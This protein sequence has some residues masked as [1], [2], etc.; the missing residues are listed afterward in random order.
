MPLPL[1]GGT[2]VTTTFGKGMARAI[3][4]YDGP[5]SRRSGDAS[6]DPDVRYSKVQ[7]MLIGRRPRLP[8]RII[9]VDRVD[10]H[11]SEL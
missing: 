3:R 2:I 6:S 10:R 11:S 9:V 7:Q 4:H 1:E 8:R 5:T